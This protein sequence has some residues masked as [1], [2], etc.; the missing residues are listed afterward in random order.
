[1]KGSGRS[2][3]AWA[4]CCADGSG[5]GSGAGA[6]ADPVAPLPMVAPAT[7]VADAPVV[8]PKANSEEQPDATTSRRSNDDAK[9]PPPRSVKLGRNRWPGH[10]TGAGLVSK[11]GPTR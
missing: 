1:M 8:T 2:A 4:R 7:G 10:Y 5:A 6:P 3:A 11:G 9:S